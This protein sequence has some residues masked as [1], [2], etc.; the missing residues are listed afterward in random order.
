MS[1]VTINFPLPASG[2]NFYGSIFP[3]CCKRIKS[4]TWYTTY[5]SGQINF[6]DCSVLK[7]QLFGELSY[8]RRFYNMGSCPTLYSCSILNCLILTNV[9][10][11][12]SSVP[13]YLSG[14][15]G[16]SHPTFQGKL[17]V[18]FDFYFGI[19]DVVQ[20]LHRRWRRWKNKRFNCKIEFA[21]P[22]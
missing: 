16:V 21:P 2:W 11:D 9:E 15:L 5:K 14:R 10:F 13:N 18:L 1:V 22:E 19:G 7:S 3:G 8:T 4:L 17:L 12:V 20:N 6:A